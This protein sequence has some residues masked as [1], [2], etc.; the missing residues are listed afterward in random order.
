MAILAELRLLI[1]I[2]PL[3]TLIVLVLP[4]I[5]DYICVFPL[6]RLCSP[7]RNCAYIFLAQS[8]SGDNVS[9]TSTNLDKLCL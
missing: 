6:S 3:H 5:V 7:L 8:G 9:M 4:Q 1:G 2:Y